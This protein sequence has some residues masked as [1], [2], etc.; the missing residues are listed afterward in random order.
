MTKQSHAAPKPYYAEMETCDGIYEFEVGT[1]PA[2]VN[3]AWPAVVRFEFVY[4]T[5]VV[6]GTM[7]AQD[8]KELASH[9]AVASEWAD[10]ETRKRRVPS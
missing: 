4:G 10:H 6:G 8:A 9:L 3:N 1:T 2:D 5:N 7:T